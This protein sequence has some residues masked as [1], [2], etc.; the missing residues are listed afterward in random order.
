MSDEAAVTITRQ[1]K[2]RFLVDFG[3]GIADTVVDEPAPLGNG[4]G[5]SSSQLLVAAV[6][7]CLSASFLFASTK[8][9]EDPG[10]LTTTAKCQ[11]GR[12]ENNRLRV[13]GMEISIEL[14]L[15]PESLG[16]LER[17]LAHFEDFCTVS[18]SVRAGIPFTVTVRGPDGRVLK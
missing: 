15:E 5:P 13:T 18:Q 3:P 4:S 12:N 8:F 17:A 2:Y 16:H 6:G 11:T 14:G 10:R 7:S 9:K 1:D